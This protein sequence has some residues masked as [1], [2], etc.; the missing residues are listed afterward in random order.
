MPKVPLGLGEMMLGEISPLISM[1]LQKFLP[2]MQVL[3]RCSTEV[4]QLSARSGRLERLARLM[5]AVKNFRVQ[6][7]C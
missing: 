6:L 4:F 7:V 1:S 5:A 3:L 2:C